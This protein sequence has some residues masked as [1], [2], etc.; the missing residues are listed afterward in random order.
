MYTYIFPFLPVLDLDVKQEFAN[1][2]LNTDLFGPYMKEVKHIFLNPN[3]MIP[4][5]TMCVHMDPPI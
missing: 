4:F 5:Q 2:M 1:W 3:I